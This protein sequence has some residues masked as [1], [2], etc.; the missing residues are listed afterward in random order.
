M[1]FELSI[2]LT[3]STIFLAKLLS[4]DFFSRFYL[5]NRKR[6]QAGGVVEEKEKQV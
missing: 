2:L 6:T 5:F 4:V 3:V 1:S